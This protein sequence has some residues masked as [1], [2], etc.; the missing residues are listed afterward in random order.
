MKN[1]AILDEHNY[2]ENILTTEIED[3]E[4]AFS[5]LFVENKIVEINEGQE[6]YVG[7]HY[8]GENF[9]FL[10]NNENHST[11]DKNNL[12]VDNKNVLCF[13]EITKDWDFF[14]EIIEVN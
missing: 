9:Y 14:A 6:V 10:N 3:Y 1:F 12:K 11:V 13:N 4:Y 2:V 5:I 8:D 7:S